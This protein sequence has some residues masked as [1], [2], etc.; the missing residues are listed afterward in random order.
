MDEFNNNIGALVQ[1]LYGNKVQLMD[2][3]EGIV[4]GRWDVQGEPRP[5]DLKA[6]YEK[7]K[8]I[9]LVDLQQKLRD[10][11][12]EL[13][14]RT[15]WTQLPDAPITVEL[16]AQYGTYRK[17]LRD[18]SKQA[19]FPDGLVVWP[20]VPGFVGLDAD[21]SPLSG[22]KDKERADDVV[23]AQRLGEAVPKTLDEEKILAAEKI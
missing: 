10:F 6:F 5:T 23:K 13:L 21:L 16:K 18:V 9:L 2:L 7:N 17:A 3:G 20:A 19:S 8:S 12:S 4:I 22:D 15:D 14:T 1:V 11:R